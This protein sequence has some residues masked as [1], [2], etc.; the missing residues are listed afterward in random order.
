MLPTGRIIGVRVVDGRGARL[1][2]IAV[3]GGQRA[4]LTE[5]RGEEEQEKEEGEV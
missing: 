5:S 2:Q 1:Q 4:E 3:G